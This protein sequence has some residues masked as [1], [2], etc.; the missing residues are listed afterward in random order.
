[1]AIHPVDPVIA[2]GTSGT[3]KKPVI[4]IFK[5]PAGSE[6]VKVFEVEPS[7]LRLYDFE[8]GSQPMLIIAP[9]KL[10]VIIVLSSLK[11]KPRRRGPDRYLTKRTFLSSLADNIRHW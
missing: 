4:R 10:D 5:E 1:M 8:K 11:E 7:N 2:L 6:A 3:A 9:F